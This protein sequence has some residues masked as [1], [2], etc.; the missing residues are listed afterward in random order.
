MLFV[1]VHDGVHTYASRNP[2]SLCVTT[3]LVAGLVGDHA[4]RTPRSGLPAVDCSASAPQPELSHDLVL[5]L[6]VVLVPVFD[7]YAAR[8]SMFSRDSIYTPFRDRMSG[9]D[10]A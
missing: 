4:M 6:L 2:S 8:A 9:G 5:T 10:A 3:I 1:T 7:R